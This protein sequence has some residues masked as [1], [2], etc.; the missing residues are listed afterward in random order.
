[1]FINFFSAE[2]FLLLFS[3][4]LKMYN[5]R[6]S[7]TDTNDKIKKIKNSL[8]YLLINSF[9]AHAYLYIRFLR[10]NI[11]FKTFIKIRYKLTLE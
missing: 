1:M 2:L 9:I 5:A 3:S 10:V 7:H 8:L 11:I 4:K 6:K